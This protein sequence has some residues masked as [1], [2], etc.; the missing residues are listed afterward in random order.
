MGARTGTMLENDACNFRK[1]RRQEKWR[2]SVLVLGCN[3]CAV[4]KKYVSNFFISR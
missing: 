3:I 4:L 1:L 2:Q